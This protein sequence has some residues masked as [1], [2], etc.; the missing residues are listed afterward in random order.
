MSQKVINKE[1]IKIQYE[2]QGALVKA[3][4]SGASK[5]PPTSGATRG[6]V[7]GFSASSRKRLLEKLAR[8]KPAKA[9][10]MT[11]TYPAEYPDDSTEYKAHL[12]AFLEVVR[13]R[14]PKSSAI[15]RLEFQERGAPH[16]HLMFFN[17]P[18][19]NVKEIKKHWKRIIGTDVRTEDMQLDITVIRNFRMA[20][21]YVS[22]YIAKK[23]DGVPSGSEGQFNNTPYLHAHT[24]RIWGVFNAKHLPIQQ[25]IRFVVAS[26]D[27]E[28]L[29]WVKRYLRRLT[30]WQI[31]AKYRGQTTFYHNAE[32]LHRLIAKTLR[33]TGVERHITSFEVA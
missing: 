31:N 18:F 30:G 14:F 19:W 6:T 26:N 2:I 10:F 25:L 8:L 29:F 33:E 16:Y 13:R 1:C 23:S 12:R 21:S 15:W 24:G 3:T 32:G 28:H 11:L 27:I 7:N 20:M 9:I 4:V 17:L 22:K 5:Q